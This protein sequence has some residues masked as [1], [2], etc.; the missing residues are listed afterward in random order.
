MKQDT[1]LFLHGI[2]DSLEMCI[3]TIK[4][5][6]PHYRFIA[7]DFPGH[8][9][10]T[11]VHDKS[12]YTSEGYTLFVDRFINALKLS[13]PIYIFSHSMGGIAATRFT[14]AYPDLVKKLVL[15][16]PAGYGHDMAFKFRLVTIFPFGELSFS[17]LPNLMALS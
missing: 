9:K 1:I 17:S 15:F 7:V 5:F 3:S 12:V 11:L 8:G 14:Y 6:I 16:A 4:H 2:G 13:A 10:T